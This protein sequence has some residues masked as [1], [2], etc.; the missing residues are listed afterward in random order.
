ML[1]IY[2]IRHLISYNNDVILHHM[3]KTIPLTA[4]SAQL[5][6]PHPP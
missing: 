3:S 2:I 4:A 1:S 6:S 5:A